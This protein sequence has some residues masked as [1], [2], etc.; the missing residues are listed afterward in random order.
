[1][2]VKLSHETSYSSTLKD[3]VIKLLKKNPLLMP[4]QIC[5]L[6][7]LSYKDYGAYINNVKSKWNYNLKFRQGSKVKASFHHAH[8]YVYVDRLMLKIEDALN[9]GWIQSKM[10]N[11][12][13]IWKD[14]KGLGRMV[15]FVT[16][17]R[18]NLFIK[19]PALKG[20]VFQLFCNGFSMTGLIESMTILGKLLDSIRLKA[21]HAV[22]ETSQKLPY[23][24]I[25][26]FKLSNGIVIKSGD[27]THPNAIEVEFSYPDWQEKNERLLGYIYKMLKGEPSSKVETSPQKP[28]PFYIS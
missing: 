1:M 3:Q 20:R 12:A 4:K 25:D 23:M 19:A 28:K 9:R 6:L 21:A 11:R 27:K 24:I 7:G 5:K 13:L 17:G 8:G 14:P 2:I 22:F 26:L 15:W 16:T 10:K 18:V